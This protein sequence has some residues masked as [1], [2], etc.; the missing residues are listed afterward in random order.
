MWYLPPFLALVFLLAGVGLNWLAK[1]SVP[2]A[3]TI[4]V[5]IAIPYAVQAP[6]T[7]PLDRR[8]QVNIEVAVRTKVGQ[9]LNA[10]MSP[11]DTVVL[12]PPGFIGLEILPRRTYDFPGLTSYH[13]FEAWK[14]YHHMT[15]LIIDLKPEFVVQRPAERA[16]FEGRQPELAQHYVPIETIEAPP[17]LKLENL[18]LVYYV[19]DN[20]YTI[21]RRV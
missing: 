11:N 8:Q 7:M 21:Y 14:N 13:A 9:R 6:F 18:G 17:G 1:L 2:A 5:A 4:G 19:L 12:E 10:L 16:E 20:K 15:G 3:A